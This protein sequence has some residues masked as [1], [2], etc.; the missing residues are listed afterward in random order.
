MPDF[1]NPYEI[2]TTR[3]TSEASSDQLSQFGTAQDYPDFDMQNDLLWYKENDQDFSMPPHFG[4]IDFNG[5][6][7]EDKFILSVQ[8]GELIEDQSKYN[9]TSEENTKEWE[10]SSRENLKSEPHKDYYEENCGDYTCLAPLCAC[11]NGVGPVDMGDPADY[12][13]E[14]LK[15]TDVFD[16]ESNVSNETSSKKDGVGYDKKASQPYKNDDNSLIDDEVVSEEP[17]AERLMYDKE[18]DYEIFNLR[19][20]HRKNR[21]VR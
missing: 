15:I 12:T 18:D 17:E 4:D 21:L 6:P 16:H 11:C 2:H 9:P 1:T 13:L 5:D 10:L 14:N 19:I 8:T 7:S 20:I 3:P